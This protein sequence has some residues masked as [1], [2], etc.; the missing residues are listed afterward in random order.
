MAT[1]MK[2]REKVPYQRAALFDEESFTLTSSGR[3]GKEGCLDKKSLLKPR[4]EAVAQL[5]ELRTYI[6]TMAEHFSRMVHSAWV[7]ICHGMEDGEIKASLI[8]Q[9]SVKARAANAAINQARTK[10]NS[11]SALK[12]TQMEEL[13]SKISAYEELLE[14]QK[15]EHKEWHQSVNWHKPQK[16]DCQKN[17]DW[18]RKLNN[19]KNRLHGMKQ[20]LANWKEAIENSS[21]SCCFGTKK[22]FKAQYHLKEAGFENHEEWK[23]AWRKARKKSYYLFGSSDETQGNQLCQLTPES[24]PGA[25]WFSLLLR[26]GFKDDKT[27]YHIAV[28]IPYLK[29]ELKDNLENRS[30]SYHFVLKDKGLYIQPV[31]TIQKKETYESCGMFGIDI[32]DGFFS[33]TK[34]DSQ[35]KFVSSED[36]TYSNSG[37]KTVNATVMAQKL[38]EI[39][40]RAEKLHYGVAIETINLTKK[41]TKIQKR[42]ER[43]YNRMISNFPYLRYMDNCEALSLKSGV[44]LYYVSPYWSSVLGDEKYSEKLGI[45]RHQA[46]AYVIARRAQN[47]SEFYIP[48]KKGGS[49]TKKSEIK[50]SKPCA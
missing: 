41:K 3:F 24:K 36:V 44:P 28:R 49:K 17:R 46:A 13:E 48:P 4:E 35:G 39:F 19:M 23:A 14:D 12:A 34:S 37:S 30:V 27:G 6:E 40:A 22:L 26:S 16:G 20:K 9:Y 25:D 15:K 1:K 11:L 33:V 50:A 29:K 8:E 32:N 47:Y 21:F 5:A 42:W 18:K 2:I 43:K 38:S 31:V 10:M 45:S 7:M